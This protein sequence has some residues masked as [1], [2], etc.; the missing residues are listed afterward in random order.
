MQIP[1]KAVAIRDP[2]PRQYRKHIINDFL[3]TGCK[4]TF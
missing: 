1:V 4:H 2:A 3:Y